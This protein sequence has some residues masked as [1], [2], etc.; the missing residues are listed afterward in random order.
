M[1][2]KNLSKEEIE[3][4]EKMARLGKKAFKGNLTQIEQTLASRIDEAMPIVTDKKPARR[5]MPWKLLIVLTLLIAAITAFLLLRSKESVAPAIKQYMAYYEPAPFVLS[6]RERGA[7]SETIVLSAVSDAYKSG[8]YA[9]M[10]TLTKDMTK[11]GL[12]LYR[13]VA[14]LELDR[15]AEALTLLEQQP[16]DDLQD[17]RSWYLALAYL[18]SNDVEKAMPVL[19]KITQA[20]DHYKF[21]AA[22]ELLQKLPS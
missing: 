11:Q 1:K 6:E 7:E 18:R 12:D 3:E 17:M 15:V 19:K 5:S 8:D 22:T 21:R 10:L 13:A 2:G 14:L 4:L 20:S 16:N 9:A